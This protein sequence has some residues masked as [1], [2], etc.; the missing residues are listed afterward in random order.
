MSDDAKM[1]P[2]ELARMLSEINRQGWKGATLDL[3]GREVALA[4]HVCNGFAKVQKGLT[5]LS[6]GPSPAHLTSL[7]MRLVLEP[8]LLLDRAHRELWDG[9]LPGAEMQTLPIPAPSPPR[10]TFART[11]FDPKHV[12]LIRPDLTEFE[13][14]LF[15]EYRELEIGS[16]MYNA[17]WKV[18]EKLLKNHK[19]GGKS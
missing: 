10:T 6:G 13:A 16:A 5:Q 7:I 1:T 4:E 3:F 15:L 12:R 11:E 17:G 18:M 8:L 19:R 14:K 9:V 2:S